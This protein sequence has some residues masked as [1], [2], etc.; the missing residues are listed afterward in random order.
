MRSEIESISIIHG[1]SNKHTLAAALW[2]PIYHQNKEDNEHVDTRS[3]RPSTV[4]Q[5]MD[6][7]LL[8]VAAFF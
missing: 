8:S 6:L 1:L 2:D 3:G 7:V 5:E 4:G